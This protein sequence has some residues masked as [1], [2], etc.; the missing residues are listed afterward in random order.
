MKYRVL[1]CCIFALLTGCNETND[2]IRG[3]LS[4]VPSPTAVYFPDGVGVDFGEKPAKNEVMETETE[5]GRVVTRFVTYELEHDFSL[6]DK[7]LTE[8][9]EH[10]GYVRTQV[11]SKRKDRLADVR[12]S[13]GSRGIMAYYKETIDGLSKKTILVL[14]WQQ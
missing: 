13:K 9:L 14:Y 10:E 7:Q 5:Q 6:I 4:D 8:V 1:V 11:A 2:E 12:Y 3:T